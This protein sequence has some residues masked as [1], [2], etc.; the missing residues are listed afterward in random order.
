MNKLRQWLDKLNLGQHEAVLVANDIDFDALRYLSDQDLK[1]LGLSLGHRR[2]LLAAIATLSLP[3]EEPEDLKLP[4]APIASLAERRQL[5]VLFCDLV[6]STALSTELD[7]EDLST[8]LSVYRER[9]SVALARFDGHVAK[10]FG[11]GVLVYFG[12]PRAHEDDA[13]RAVR[14]GLAILEELRGVGADGKTRLHVRIGI[15]TGPVMVGELIGT[16]TAQEQTV[17]GEAPNLAARIQAI[18]EP[19]SV[20]IAAS[21][22]SL[23]GGLFDCLDLG[24]HTLKGLGG[25]VQL[26]RVQSESAVESRFEAFHTGTLGPLVGREQELALLAERWQRAKDGD[27]Q[28]VL[29]SGEPG[30]GKSRLVLNLR[31]QLADEPFTSLIHY[32]SPYHAS[33]A[34]HP[35]IGLLQ[36]LAQ[37]EQSDSTDVRLDKLGAF[38][39][40]SNQQSSEAAA[41]IPT[42]LGIPGGGARPR[43]DLTP[44]RQK[45]LILKAL[46]EL[47]VGLAQQRPVLVVYEDVHWVDPSTLEFL[48]L[49]VERVQGLPVLLLITFRPEFAPPWANHPHVTRLSLPRLPRR[50]GSALVFR[51]AGGKALPTEVLEQIVAHADGVPLFVEELTKVIVESGTLRDVGPRFELVGPLPA[52]AIPSTLQD[53]LMARLDRLASVKEVAQIASVIGREFSHELLA[54]MAAIDEAKLQ[55]ALQELIV[56]E[57]VFRRGL[58]PDASYTFKHALVQDAAYAS[59]LKSRRKQ[60]HGRIAQILEERSAAHAD[61][62]PEVIARH[63]AEAGLAQKAVD[64]WLMAGERGLQRSEYLEAIT[65][66][67]RAIETQQCLPLSHPRSCQELVLQTALG[68]ALR[69]TKG[70]GAEE[71]GRAFARALELC[72]EVEDAPQLF[73]ALYGLWAFQMVRAKCGLVSDLSRQF[74]DR[75]TAKNDSAAILVGHRQAGLSDFVLGQFS[76]AETHFEQVRALYDRDRH[77]SLAFQFAQDPLVCCL[78]NQAWVKWILGS[79]DAALATSQQAVSYACELGHINT[80]VYAGWGALATLQFR[81]DAAA[82]KAQAS[83]LIALCEERQMLMWRAWDR[84]IEGWALGQLGAQEAALKQIADNLAELRT[85]GQQWSLPYYLA[86]YAETLVLCNQIDAA[87]DSISEGLQLAGATM[88]RWWEAELNRLNGEFML[89]CPRPQEQAAE[90]AFAKSLLIARAQGAKSLEL[91]SAAS[92]AALWAKHG[93]RRRAHDLLAP[94]YEWF[95]EGFETADLRHTR[96]QV[97]QLAAAP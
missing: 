18:A 62:Q 16:G 86:L 38:L 60:L 40:Q 91:R 25:E 50:H 11:D 57:L 95:A 21:T 36:R 85:S 68:A 44:Q 53:S 35:V 45:Q 79:P 70:Y 67:T 73:P 26:W 59:L 46:I 30:I 14:A 54:A 22:R 58:P 90:E 34:F 27:G 15:A 7:P 77:R 48:D 56:A 52:L 31:E 43:L 94:V 88:E 47:L 84:V 19:D 6:G 23:I 8:L 66:L 69:A 37:F 17:V 97:E 72:E 78:A 42:L 93:E 87:M 1:D 4:A 76:N 32:C 2:K 82:I 33:S 92:L 12:Y 41:M 10:Y 24:I 71:T 51:A 83:S 9:C 39:A 20:V 75:A 64:Y 13:E 74:L 5:T 65:H 49:I 61:G 29:L 55:N 80:Q 63:Y 96:M 89:L 28:V 3:P 81:R